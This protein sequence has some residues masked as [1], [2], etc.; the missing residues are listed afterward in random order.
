MKYLLEDYTF[1]VSAKTVTFNEWPS[2]AGPINISKIL[3]ITNI[4]TSQIIY[5]FNE[6]SLSGSL[7]GNVLTLNTSTTGMANTDSLQIFIEVRHSTVLSLE[8]GSLGSVESP[9]SVNVVNTPPEPETPN[10][11]R[12]CSGVLTLTGAQPYGSA[13][14]NMNVD[15]SVTPQIFYMDAQPDFDFHI[16]HFAIVLAD[17]SVSHNLFG[18]LN[19][20]VNGFSLRSIDEGVTSCIISNARTGGELIAQSG[21]T[22]PY[23][24]EAKSWELT[25]WSDSGDDATTV[26]IPISRFMPNGIRIGRG[27]TTKIEAEVK[28]DLTG[29]S[30]FEIIYFGYRNY[31]VT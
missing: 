18:K 26:A 13:G 7:S 9:L 22:E 16:M 30:L 12:Y 20:L 31:P 19:P 27:T 6:S 5:I 8:P 15:G 23:G 21:L 11:H 2:E 29:L 14:S 3:V 1:D 28:D 4:T 17:L 25:N 24:S 10:I